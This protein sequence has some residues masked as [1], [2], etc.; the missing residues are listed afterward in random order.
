[1]CANLLAQ[2]LEPCAM[3]MHGD[4][5]AV[6]AG[7]QRTVQAASPSCHPG[8]LSSGCASA[9]TCPATGCIATSLVST[10]IALAAPSAD[11]AAAAPAGLRSFVAPPLF[12]PPQ[13]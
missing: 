1:M 13:A 12:P 3:H 6:G 2:V 5:A 11:A 7:G 10:D 9:G 8:D 4:H